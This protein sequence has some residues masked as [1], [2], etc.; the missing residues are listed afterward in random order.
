M[1]RGCGARKLNRINSSL[2]LVKRD[3]VA[4][5][6]SEPLGRTKSVAYVPSIKCYL[7][8][9]RSQTRRSESQEKMQAGVQPPR[10]RLALDKR[11]V[12]SLLKENGSSGF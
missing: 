5:G 6:R 3:S 10:Y 9:G 11:R 4:F 12:N 7:C 2:A 8:P 1:L